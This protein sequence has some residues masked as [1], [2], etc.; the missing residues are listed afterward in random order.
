MKV[1]FKSPDFTDH[2]EVTVSHEPDAAE[3]KDRATTEEEVELEILFGDDELDSSDGDGT[4]TEDATALKN[5]PTLTCGD[6][7]E[8]RPAGSSIDIWMPA[9]LRCAAHTLNLLATTDVEKVLRSVSCSAIRDLLDRTMGKARSLWKS[10]NQSS[11]SAEITFSVISNKIFFMLLLYN[12]CVY[13][14]VLN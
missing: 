4:E 11:K 10:A 1:L 12:A 5:P 2:G 3:R 6:I 14:R 7:L 9:H 13:M 8:N